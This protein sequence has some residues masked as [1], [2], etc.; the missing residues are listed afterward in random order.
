[1]RLMHKLCAELG[2]RAGL[3]DHQ[4]RRFEIADPLEPLLQLSD[5]RGATERCEHQCRQRL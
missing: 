5:H 3:G 2:S 1:M 4:E